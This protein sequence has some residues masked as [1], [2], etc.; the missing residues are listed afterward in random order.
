MRDAE[1]QQLVGGDAISISVIVVAFGVAS[2]V[3]GAFCVV[4]EAPT[5]FEPEQLVVGA[6]I[7]D[8]AVQR[9]GMMSSFGAAI[10]GRFRS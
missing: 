5:A 3:A 4:P 1:P 10:D 8:A 2:A 9:I 7:E 6:K